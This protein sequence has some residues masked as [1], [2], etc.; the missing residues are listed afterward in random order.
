MRYAVAVFVLAAVFSVLSGCA[1]T[2][3]YSRILAGAGALTVT[4]PDSPTHD[5]KFHLRSTVDFDLNTNEAADRYK[6]IRAYL[7]EECKDISIVDDKFLPTGGTGIAGLKL[8][9]YVIKVKCI[10]YFVAPPSS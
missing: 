3:G 7:E 6:V 2:Q 10:H 8:G 4:E 5:Y 1:G 9:T